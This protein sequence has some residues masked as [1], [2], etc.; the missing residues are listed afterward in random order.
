MMKEPNEADYDV[1]V[2]VGAVEVTFK[3]TSSHFTYNS[4]AVLVDP[5][6]STSP[7]II[8]SPTGDTYWSNAVQGMARQLAL[9]LLPR[10]RR[11]TLIGAAIGAGFGLI[12]TQLV[13]GQT[14]AGMYVPQ[15]TIGVVVSHFIELIP[16]AL[17]GAAMG[18]FSAI[19]MSKTSKMFAGAAVGAG[20]GL[21]SVVVLAALGL[22]WTLAEV[23][24]VQIIPWALIFAA[25][26]FF[27]GQRRTAQ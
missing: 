10:R 9:K 6:T 16:L 12:F 21:I 4:R 23:L 24:L 1:K 15:T 25:I 19:V 11:R 3:P 26:G 22:S 7:T 5:G 2:G 27:T 18:F 14:P 13:I 20:I 17:L 8:T